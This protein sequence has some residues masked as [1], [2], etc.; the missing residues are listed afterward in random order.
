M[1]ELHD[2]TV[3]YETVE[4]IHTDTHEA[5]REPSGHEEVTIWSGR[6]ACCDVEKRSVWYNPSHVLQ[7]EYQPSDHERKPPEAHIPPVRETILFV[8]VMVLIT[9]G[10]IYLLDG[11]AL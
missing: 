11:A 10:L 6:C 1:T 3:R 4:G 5:A 8:A 7:V 9:G 2:I